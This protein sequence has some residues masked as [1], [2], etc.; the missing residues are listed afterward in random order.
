V[1]ERGGLTGD[2]GVYGLAGFVEGGGSSASLASGVEVLLTAELFA[3]ELVY[4]CSQSVKIFPLFT[5]IR[6]TG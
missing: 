4:S 1:R 5:I 6:H 2:V 3:R